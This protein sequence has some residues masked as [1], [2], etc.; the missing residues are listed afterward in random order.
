MAIEF[1]GVSF[2]EFNSWPNPGAT[3]QVSFSFW[4]IPTNIASG[5]QRLFGAETHMEMRMSS[6]GQM[7]TDI[8]EPPT[9][10]GSNTTFVNNVLYHIVSQGDGAADEHRLYV[11]G[12]F[13]SEELAATGTIVGGSTFQVG[14][15]PGGTATQEFEGFIEDLRSY[16]RILSAEEAQ[17][18]FAAR[19][20][21]G[22][23]D[24]LTM[25]LIFNEQPPNTT[26]LT[27]HPK[28]LTGTMG[29]N[30]VTGT[31]VYRVSRGLSFKRRMVRR[32][33]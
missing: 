25:R 27:T 15:R 23:T 20:R 9:P 31:P 8:F 18:L 21:D 17:T 29:V 32:P 2:V 33:L 22:I 26:L 28:E 1:D 4:F 19:G 16:N 10:T 11:N 3:G 14:F 12:V 6:S 24:G 13:D 30:S 7:F 5:T